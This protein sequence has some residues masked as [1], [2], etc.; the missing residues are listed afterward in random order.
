MKMS[1][2]DNT[3]FVLNSGIKDNRTMIKNMLEKEEWVLDYQIIK[4]DGSSIADDDFDFEL[5]E[6]IYNTS[7]GG[8][9]ARTGYMSFETR[10]ICTGEENADIDYNR[11][12][13]TVKTNSYEGEED[14]SKNS[15]IFLKTPN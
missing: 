5:G 14:F 12:I 1:F 2:Y 6:Y 7:T 3:Q 10:D 15:K 11:K 13:F 8:Y 4:S 9:N